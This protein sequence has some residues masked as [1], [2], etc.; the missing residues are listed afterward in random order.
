MSRPPTSSLRPALSFRDVGHRVK[1]GDCAQTLRVFACFVSL[2]FAGLVVLAR[3]LNPIPSRT[4]PLNSSAPMVLW[5]KSWESRSL[6]GLP[7]TKTSSFR[8]RDEKRRFLRAF[9]AQGKAAFFV[10]ITG[11]L[12]ARNFSAMIWRQ[13]SAV[14][15][16]AII[17]NRARSAA[18]RSQIHPKIRPEPRSHSMR[19]IIR[20]IVAGLSIGSLA[21]LLAFAS[22][23]G[24]FAQAK[25]TAPAAQAAPPP[26][27]PAP[28]QIPLTEKQI[29]GVLASQKELDAITEKLPEDAKE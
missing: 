17:L 2:S 11:L 5:L 3:S 12:T 25:Q 23:T 24:A 29:E 26:A 4:R 28:K 8:F 21:A 10:A 16:T 13:D 27:E 6:P 20:P 1:P 7:R 15:F 18:D 9:D 14:A 22:A 19:P